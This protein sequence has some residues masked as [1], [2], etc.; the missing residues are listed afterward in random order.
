MNLLLAQTCNRDE[1]LDEMKAYFDI[2]I[3]HWDDQQVGDSGLTRAQ[4][5]HLGF[6]EFGEQSYLHRALEEPL[7]N[8]DPAW[9]LEYFTRFGAE[10]SLETRKLAYVFLSS[11]QYWGQIGVMA[12]LYFFMGAQFE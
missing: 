2:A 4:V 10:A 5:L 11:K 12:C 7:A 6:Q 3:E 1:E 8:I 9:I